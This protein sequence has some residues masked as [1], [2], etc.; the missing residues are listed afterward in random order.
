VCVGDRDHGC[1]F[2]SI[3]A[4]RP[5]GGGINEPLNVLTH[6]KRRLAR[7]R[8]W[9]RP[10]APIYQ[11]HRAALSIHVWVS[12]TNAAPQPGCAS[13]NGPFGASAARAF[14]PTKPV[15]RPDNAGAT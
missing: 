14:P 9:A 1:V 11:G 2:P 4:A 10:C 13:L 7:H 8:Y 15:D 12:E 3:A 5:S 6:C